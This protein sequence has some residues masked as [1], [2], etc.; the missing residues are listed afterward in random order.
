MSAQWTAATL[1]PVTPAAPAKGRG[2]TFGRIRMREVRAS[3]VTPPEDRLA[4]APMRD[5]FHDSA[6][7]AGVIR[8]FFE[9]ADDPQENVI[10]VYL[11][12][13]GRALAAERVYRGTVNSANVA[14]RD[15]ARGALAFN[16]VGVLIAHNHPSGNPAPSAQDMAYTRK[17]E[18]ALA[19]L[20][21]E[22]VDHVVITAR[23]H[24][25]MRGQGFLVSG[26]S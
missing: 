22:L 4:D 11:D 1:F 21:V 23:G 24:S 3:L 25:S 6:L 8:E 20:E 2:G 19:L 17:L 16:A 5:S 15:I 13:H 10:A 9:L 14:C 12:S 26:V 7:A 18:Q